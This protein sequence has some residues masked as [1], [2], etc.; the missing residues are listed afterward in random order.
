[1]I[2]KLLIGCGLR[3]ES[4]KMAMWKLLRWVLVGMA[5]VLVTVG[6][7]AVALPVLVC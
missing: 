7:L 5:L 3:A 1:M 4:G 2:W 6:L